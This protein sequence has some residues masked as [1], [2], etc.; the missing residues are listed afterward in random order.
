[1]IKRQVSDL[2]TPELHRQHDI[3][4]GEASPG[5]RRVSV[6]TQRPMDRYLQRKLISERLWQ[7]AEHLYRD[8]TAANLEPSVCMKWAEYLDAGLPA[9]RS[10]ERKHDGYT[11]F[12]KA[13]DSAGPA[14]YGVL[15]WV[16]CMG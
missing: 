16:I 11:K 14:S 13:M 4:D 2:G 1:M 10:G 12:W 8:F 9:Y 15:W 3:R 5:V 6:T 7:A